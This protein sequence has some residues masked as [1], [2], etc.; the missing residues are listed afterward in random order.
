MSTQLKL[1]RG[2]TAQHST[3]TGASGEITVDTTKKTIVVHDGSTAGGVP[4]AKENNPTLT[5]NV[6]ISGTGNRI[7]GDFSNATVAN[8]VM[9][10]TNSENNQTIVAALP[11]GTSNVVAFQVNS[12]SSDPANASVGDIRIPAG[13]TDFRIR[14]DRTGT[15]AFMPMTFWTSGTEKFRIA[16]DATGTFTFGGTAPRITGDFSN[17]TIANRVMFQTSTVNGATSIS[18]VPNGTNTQADLFAFNGSDPNNASALIARA[19]NTEITFRSAITGTGTYLPMTFYTG[20]SERVRVDTSGNVGIGTSSPNFGA[21]SVALAVNGSSS[22]ALNLKVADVGAFTVSSGSGYTALADGRASTTMQFSLGGTERA[23]ID[24]SGN[25]MVGTTGGSGR[26][27]VVGVD[28]TSSNNAA[29]FYNSSSVTLFAARNDGV[30]F[31]G[32][33]AASPYNLTS[34]NAANVYVDSAGALYRS[35]SSLKYKTDVQA[36]THGLAEVMALR[37]VT[38]RGK[39]DG[40]K[41]F[42][43]LIA[44][45]VHEAGL[46]EFVQY[47]EDGT[48]DALAYGNMV[49]LA[50]KAIQEQQALINDLTA[51]IAALEAPSNA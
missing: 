13:A 27:R 28:S 22:A 1:R 21:N 11:N 39:N 32:T 34:G 44:E 5:G 43:G 2:T 20:G 14:S 46:T 7:T 51:R 18:A 23:R 3:F 29:A 48:P 33:A 45:E 17:A 9:F 36:A 40:E 30:I 25:F 38:Y 6:T 8:R 49:S 19:S 35:T 12:S 26:L 42:G 15:G 24:S 10:Q 31:T 50:F 4:L 16:A 47:A 37:P 41:V